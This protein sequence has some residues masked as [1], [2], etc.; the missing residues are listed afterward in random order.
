MYRVLDFTIVKDT[1]ARVQ[2]I[3]PRPISW[4]L[5]ISIMLTFLFQFQLEVHAV[6]FVK[7]PLVL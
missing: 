3:V 2:K 7:V 5:L 6:I 4:L 1:Y